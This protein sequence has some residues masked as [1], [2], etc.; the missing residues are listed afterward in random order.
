MDDAIRKVEELKRK[1]NEELLAILEEE[2]AK[3][4][5]REFLL[6]GVCVQHSQIDCLMHISID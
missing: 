5:E 1:Q 6:A 2:Q 4:N 3:E